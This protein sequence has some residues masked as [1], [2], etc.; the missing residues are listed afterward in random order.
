[1]KYI[2]DLI[3]IS[4]LLL[5]LHCYFVRPVKRVSLSYHS[6]VCQAIG[7]STSFHFPALVTRL[8]VA[9]GQLILLALCLAFPPAMAIGGIRLLHSRRSPKLQQLP[10]YFPQLGATKKNFT[11]RL[12][13]Y[14][15]CVVYACVCV[16]VCVCVGK[17][18]RRKYQQQ[19]GTLAGGQ[20]PQS[21][22]Y[23]CH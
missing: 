13:S 6:T 19:V 15:L 22:W 11:Q 8:S 4:F 23:P 10:S 18:K 21:M 3:L 1:M 16:C 14:K 12:F 2:L 5:Y 17:I 20:D 7:Q 9:Y